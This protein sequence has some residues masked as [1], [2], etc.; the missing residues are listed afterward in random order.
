MD[1][2]THTHTHTYA[3]ACIHTDAPPHKNYAYRVC[4]LTDN[5]R[6]ISIFATVALF[7]TLLIFFGR[8]CFGW[9][10]GLSPIKYKV[11]E[12]VCIAALLFYFDLN[13][14]F[15]CLWICVITW[16]LLMN[17][18]CQNHTHAHTNTHTRLHSLVYMHTHTHMHTHKHTHT[19]THTPA[20]ALAHTTHTDTH[21]HTHRGTDETLY[22]SDEKSLLSPL[23]SHPDSVI[24]ISDPL[25]RYLPT[26]QPK[27]TH[28]HVHI[29]THTHKKKLTRLEARRINQGRWARDIQNYTWLWRYR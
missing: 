28:T 9:F 2:H 22:V 19:H 1:A 3:H 23:K 11:L 29:H 16:L 24:M 8:L 26:M 14:M 27:H 10:K 6:G 12:G 5:L 15:S 18:V 20:L 13:I 7:L 4:Y 25:S 21:T 17:A